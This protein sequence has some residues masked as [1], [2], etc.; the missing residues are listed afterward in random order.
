MTPASGFSAEQQKHHRDMSGLG[1]SGNSLTQFANLPIRKGNR[2]ITVR[3]PLHAQCCDN[4]D[5]TQPF[6]S[7]NYSYA[8]RK[9]RSD[10]LIIRS[11][12]FALLCVAGV[13][14]LYLAISLAHSTEGTM[15]GGDFSPD[16]LKEDRR[17]LDDL[18]QKMNDGDRTGR[19]SSLV[20][21]QKIDSAG[22]S[23]SNPKTVPRAML[24]V[25]SEIVK[26][27][28]LVIHGEAV[29]R[30]RRAEAL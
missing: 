13:F 3:G 4:D 20:S 10:L 25:N 6:H 22:K 7:Q 28:Q 21:T 15:Q 1:M 16:I 26:H 11:L 19:E 5:E 30:K 17:F 9:R 23:E 2:A 14:V 12:I 27:G 8:V 29:K 24:V 18:F